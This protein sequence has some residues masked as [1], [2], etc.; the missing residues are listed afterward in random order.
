MKPQ[1]HYRPASNWINDPNGLVHYNGWYHMFYQYNPHGD[2]WGDIHWGHARS[3]DLLH[4]ETLPIALIPDASQ[5]ELHFFSG[6]CCKDEQ[7]HPHFF[8][9]SIGRPEDGRDHVHGAQQW[10]AE[11]TDE[12]LTQLCQT[13]LGALTGEIH[14]GMHV[15]DWRDPCVFRHCGQYIM[16]LGG[17]VE[18]RGCVLL[19]TSPDLRQWTFRHILA[20]SDQADGTPWE[21]PNL[22]PLDGRFVLIYSP[23]AEVRAK[24]GMLDDDLHFH[25][26]WEE[27]VDPSAR[28]GFY[29]PQVFRD[30]QG[31]TILIGWMPECD[32]V[33]HKGWSGVMSL[34]RL[35]SITENGLHAAT[36]PDVDTLPGVQ[37]L[38]IA[39]SELPGVWRIDHSPKEYT[40]LS[41]DQD[42]CMTLDRQHS[43]LSD[44]PDKHILRRSVPM[45]TVNEIYIAADDTTVEY[46][47]NGKWISARVY[48]TEGK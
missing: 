23:C 26:E 46:M 4:W 12:D 40:L 22:F 19:Y 20:Q 29:A 7:G 13:S 38:Q 47:V 17:C 10:F 37:R 8:Y 36:V 31:C 48:P 33:E 2:A 25:E 30:D 32:H 5:G 42:G 6:G 21:C 34:P 28:N 14:G 27:V 43:S 18:E 45:K 15:R 44:A 35:L 11:P 16:V 24:V 3:R 1:W 39:A 9:T 41:L